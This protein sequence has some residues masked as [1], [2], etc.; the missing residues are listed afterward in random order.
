MLV[1]ISKSKRKFEITFS[2]KTLNSDRAFRKT[3]DRLKNANH[4]NKETAVLIRGDEKFTA[5]NKILRKKIKDL[6]KAIFKKKRKRKR[7]KILNFYK[8]DE[9]EN[10]ILFFSSAKVARAR[11]RAAALEETEAQQKRTAADRKMQQAIAREKKTREA[12]EKKARK[13]IERIA[14]REKAA[15][16]KA[17]KTAKREAK[18]AQKTR[19]IKLHKVKIEK[20]RTER[21]QI[22][23]SNS[24]KAKV[25]EKRSINDSEI[26]RSRK[27]ARIVRSHLNNQYL[28]TKSIL[29]QDSIIIRYSNATNNDSIIVTDEL[30]L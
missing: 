24:Q 5:E 23:K 2:L 30:Q 1:R 20:K 22:K 27:R 17:A 11:E 28:I 21:A 9:M 10:Q 19:E 14:A 16:E 26:N 18:K 25:S 6:R 8:E 12:A 7:E 13:E 3:Y 29:Q 4:I 15:R